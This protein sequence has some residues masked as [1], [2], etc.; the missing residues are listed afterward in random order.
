MCQVCREGHS[1]AA[2]L[3]SITT[4][5][6]C[7]TLTLLPQLVICDGCSQGWHQLC[8]SPAVQE[9]VVNSDL[10]WLCKSCD[11]KVARSK[12]AVDVAVGTWTTG[13]GEYKVE[14]KREWLEGL[15]LHSLI[16]YVF[17]VEKSE[18]HFYSVLSCVETSTD[19][20]IM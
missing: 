19:A 2:N 13:G 18:S 4:H 11:V 8:H 9:Q 16:E 14:E 3:V 6:Y 7:A 17:S 15:P 20:G 10:S 1:P 12:P 5:S